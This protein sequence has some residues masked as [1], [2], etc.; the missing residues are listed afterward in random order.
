MAATETTPET[1]AQVLDRLGRDLGLSPAE[2]ATVLNTTSAETA[3]WRAGA[4][5]PPDEVGE[6]LTK[7]RELY[8]RLCDTFNPPAIIPAYLRTGLPYLGGLTPADAL[9]AGRVDRVEAALDALDHGI[10]V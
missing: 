6:R 10:F 5:G 8:W 1:L 4:G 7:L 2:L 3:G 9:L